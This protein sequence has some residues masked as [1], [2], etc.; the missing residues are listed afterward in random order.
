M[1]GRAGDRSPAW[2]PDGRGQRRFLALALLL[3]VGLASGCAARRERRAR[4]PEVPPGPIVRSVEL[5]GVEYFEDDELLEYLNLQPTPVISLSG[6]HYYVPGLEAVD[7]RRIKEVYAAHGHY[8]TEVKRIDVE[9]ETKGNAR[10]WEKK[11]ARRARRG[12]PPPKPRKAIARVQIE[13]EEGDAATVR[14]RAFEWGESP[15]V[16]RAAIEGKAKLDRG[17]VF[18][19]PALRES[20][21]AMKGQLRAEGHAH[22]EV[23]EYAD[24]HTKEGWA[25]LRF[26]I[27]PGPRVSIGQFAVEGLKL[28]PKDLVLRECEDFSGKPFSPRTLQRIE[29]SVYAMGVFSAVSV[30]EGPP[31]GDGTVDVVVKV[32]ETKLRGYKIGVGF[33]IDPVR[34]EQSASF[35]YRHDSIFGR[36]TRMELLIRAGYAELPAIYDP[37][38]HGPL[39]EVELTF[40]KKGLLEKHLVWTERPSIELGIWDGYQYWTIKNRIGVSRFFT[41]WV[42]ANIGYTNRFTDFFNISPTLNTNNTLLGRDFRDPYFISYVGAQITLH[43]VDDII[44]PENGAR[45]IVGY[46]IANRFVG[47]QFNAH[48]IPLELQLLYR[49]HDRIALQGRAKVGFIVPYG[50]E[51]FAGLPIDLKWYLGGAYDV[52]G[53]PLRQLS[54]RVEGSCDAMGENCDSIPVGGYSMALFNVEPRVRL[55]SSLWLATFFDV[56]DVRAAVADFDARGW[57]ATTGGGLRYDTP[58][59][60]IRVDFGYRLTRDDNRFP[61]EPRFL[62]GDENYAIHIAI[63]QVF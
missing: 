41:R 15:G 1:A 60:T 40:R 61:V 19:I 4:G 2:G 28:V 43:L 38:Q 20:A 32:Q 14:S 52:R 56:G 54:P 34:W 27:E 24:V 39:A 49:P 26:Q 12:K 57:Q 22:A 29:Q 21:A 8:G 42:E 7:R 48:K 35:R 58:V 18:E 62:P 45:L 37:Q 11:A 23:T 36:L 33:G 51:Q 63:G 30:Q 31:K 6:K 5:E 59:G 44:R 3:L 25:D 50:R 10:R 13:V 9:V 53:W 46:D 55:V 47:S 17:D 16:D